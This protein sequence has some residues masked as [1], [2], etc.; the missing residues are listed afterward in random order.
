MRRWLTCCLLLVVLPAW[1]ATEPVVRVAVMPD[2]VRVG[3]A[4]ELQ[5][6]VLVPTW[7]TKPPVY[8]SF[9]LANA[10]TRLPP[11][12][13]YPTSER[14]GRETWSGIV[15]SYRVWPLL[16]ARYRISGETLTVTFANPGAAPV[17]AEVEVP[18]IVLR[19]IVPD[20]AAELDPYIAGRSLKLSLEVEGDISG[21]EAGDALVLTYRAELDGIFGDRD[22]IEKISREIKN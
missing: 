13:S 6:T 11:D 15:R 4:A 17:T 21:L 10:I 22:A 8:P 18:E 12:S 3:E 14:V 9:E 2:T 20:G 1:A 5:V 16:D 7:F 19:G